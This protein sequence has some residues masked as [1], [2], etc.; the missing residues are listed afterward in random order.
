MIRCISEAVPVLV[1]HFSVF[2]L[3]K[4]SFQQMRRPSVFSPLSNQ[5]QS[6]ATTV[7]ELGR[8]QKCSRSLQEE[9]SSGKEI[10][11]R[12]QHRGWLENK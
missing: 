12:K 7:L 4:Q 8:R 10:H 2:T 1:P 6:N 11:Y 5:Y 3:C 9:I